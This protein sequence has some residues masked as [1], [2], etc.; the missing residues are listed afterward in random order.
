[1]LEKRLTPSVVGNVTRIPRVS[2]GQG[3]SGLGG[4]DDLMLMFSNGRYVLR[5]LHL[6]SKQTPTIALIFLQ[7]TYPQLVRYKIQIISFVVSEALLFRFL[8]LFTTGKLP[9]QRLATACNRLPSL[10]TPGHHLATSYHTRCFLAS[11]L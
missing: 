7:N 4:R 5:F 9:E 3:V 10:T 1:M 8:H 11:H 6:K 2:N